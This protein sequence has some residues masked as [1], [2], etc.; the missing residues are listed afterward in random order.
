MTDGSQHAKP[1]HVVVADTYAFVQGFDKR[2][3]A[4]RDAENRNDKASEI[5]VPSRYTVIPRDDG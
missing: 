1:Y 3:D 5:G 4:I 2:G